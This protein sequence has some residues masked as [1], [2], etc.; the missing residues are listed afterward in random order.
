[1]YYITILIQNKYLNNVKIW[2]WIKVYSTRLKIFFYNMDNSCIPLISTHVKLTVTIK[3]TQNAIIS[4]YAIFI[5]IFGLKNECWSEVL[6]F[7]IILVPG[8]C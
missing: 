7:R 1:M 5:F 6:K 3:K 4:K 8:Q 2:G